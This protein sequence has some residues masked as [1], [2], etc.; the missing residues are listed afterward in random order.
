[1]EFVATNNNADDSIRYEAQ[2][3]LNKIIEKNQPIY[4]QFNNNNNNNNINKNIAECINNNSG[5]NLK[6]TKN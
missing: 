3:A 6:A 2:I 5:M 1:M 4:Y